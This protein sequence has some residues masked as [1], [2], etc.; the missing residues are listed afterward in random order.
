MSFAGGVADGGTCLAQVPPRI[1]HGEAPVRI[2]VI[3]LDEDTGRRE[4]IEWRMRELGLGWERLAAVHGSRLDASHEALVDRGAHA[5]RGLRFS[6]GEIGCWLSHRMAQQMIAEGADEMALILEDDLRI[7]DDL[8]KVL[9]RLERGA[10]GKFDVIRLHRYKLQRKYVPVRELDANRTIGFVRPADSGAQA[11][12]MS[13]E[14][15][16]TLIERVPR[17]VHLADHTL[18][19]HW[20]HGLEVCSVDP[21]VVLHD[22]RGRSSIGA[23][24]GSRPESVSPSHFFR[25]KLH[26]IERKCRR[27]VDYHRMLRTSR[28][29][30]ELP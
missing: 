29:R 19:Q 13:R 24:P 27:R 22:D 21:P 23:C 26:Q 4:R 10:A 20:T 17:M 8:P 28:R 15:A 9:D 2:I 6:P 18:Y 7:Q 11:Y 25:R 16:R 5:A 14:A 30:A 1:E 3:N 12:V